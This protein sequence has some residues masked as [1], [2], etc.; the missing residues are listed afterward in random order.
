[1]ADHSESVRATHEELVASEATRVAED[2]AGEKMKHG[3]ALA[4]V[5]AQV[6]GTAAAVSASDHSESVMA[7]HE[8]IEE[9]D[10]NKR[11]LLLEEE[12]RRQEAAARAKDAHAEETAAIAAAS[13][14]TLSAAE[15]KARID[16][17]FD[18]KREQLR[19]DQRIGSSGLQR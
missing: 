10:L 18:A 2:I 6:E 3:E 11:A 13:N 17:E 14:H 16:A 5:Q 19:R 15:R 4:R 7:R 8:E 12:N 1:M 9:E